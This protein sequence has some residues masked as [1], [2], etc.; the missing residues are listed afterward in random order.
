[1]DRITLQRHL[2]AHFEWFH[3]HPELG[4]AEFET[5]ARIRD[6]LNGAGIEILDT[7]LDT[8]LVARITGKK[9]APVVALRSDIDALPLS[10]ASGLP[11]SSK[12]EGRMHACG[13]DFHLTAL[14]GAAFLLNERRD[15]L[16]GTAKLIFQPAE[17][18]GSGAKA[19][20]ETGAL[21]DVREI[22]GLHVSPAGS[23]GVI[24]VSPG[25]IT[26]AVGGF[27]IAITGKGGHASAPQDCID[28]VIAAARIINAAQTIVSRRIDPFDKAVVSVTHVAAG[29]TWNVIPH[30]ALLEGTIRVIGTDRFKGIA[31]QLRRICLGASQSTDT[32]IDYRW[33]LGAPSVQNDPSLTEYVIETAKRLGLPVKSGSLGMGGEDFSLY[34]ERIP[35]VFFTIGVG[36]PQSVHHPCF[37]ADPAQLSTGS[38]LLAAVGADA[39]TR[40]A[41]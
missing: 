27:R 15:A 31:E 28:P 13:H 4:N 23:P 19:V 18:C 39:L 35:G 41:Q 12:N 32:E 21:D 6:I 30:D 33:Q 9:D 2:Q 16:D 7:G 37:I 1:M 38:E 17:E 24:A 34:Q 10:E 26:A 29:N 25:P 36:S 40:L 8:G 14:L 3:R 5:T 11:Y 22:Y 20:L